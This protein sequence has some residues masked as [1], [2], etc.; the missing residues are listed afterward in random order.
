M[1]WNHTNIYTTEMDLNE[2]SN[3]INASNN[4]TEQNRT[5]TLF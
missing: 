2:F 4:R 3:L 1:T 5:E